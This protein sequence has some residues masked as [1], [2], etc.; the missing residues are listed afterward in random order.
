M[1]CHQFPKATVALR[2]FKPWGFKLNHTCHTHTVPLMSLCKYL[3]FSICISQPNLLAGLFSQPPPDTVIQPHRTTLVSGTH[4][5]LLCPPQ[6][7]IC[8]CLCPDSPLPS[9]PTRQTPTRPPRLRSNACPPFVK[10]ALS[11]LL[12]PAW[13]CSASSGTSPGCQSADPGGPRA[14]QWVRG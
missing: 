3:I 13:W 9:P 8:I 6:L 14:G 4:H 7:P 12:L 1:S 2:V 5:A 10:P 11:P